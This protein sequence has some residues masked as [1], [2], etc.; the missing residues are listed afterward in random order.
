M[1]FFCYYGNSKV[2]MN[3]NEIEHANPNAAVRLIDIP[4]PQQQ[5]PVAAIIDHEEQVHVQRRNVNLLDS[6]L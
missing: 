3:P 6:W 5:N 2:Q 4:A 1:E